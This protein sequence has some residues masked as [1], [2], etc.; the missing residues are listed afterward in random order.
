MPLTNTPTGRTSMRPVRISEGVTRSTFTKVAG[1]EPLPG[2]VLVEQLGLGE[3]SEVWT[4][5]T[6]DGLRKA[7]KFVARDPGPAGGDAQLRRECE[8]FL[9]VKE[10]RHPFLLAV[11]WAE[12]VG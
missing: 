2:Y 4:C 8:A 7:V 1:T 6:P 3:F 11:E 9:R 12:V 5:R 10:I